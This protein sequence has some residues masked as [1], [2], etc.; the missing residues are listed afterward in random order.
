[1][2]W[3]NACIFLGV[4]GRGTPRGNDCPFVLLAGKGAEAAAEAAGAPFCGVC[5]HF[6][7]QGVKCSVCGHLGHREASGMEASAGRRR[8][9][10]AAD[11]EARRVRNAEYV[12][13]QTARDKSWRTRLAEE[14][15]ERM[16]ARCKRASET[17]ESPE[18]RAERRPFTLA[19]PAP[20]TMSQ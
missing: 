17:G 13:R 14:R 5:Q 4:R 12:E 7:F 16:Q 9:A 6:H 20:E 19:A 18:E 10:E 8:L 3:T 1:M 2:L 11:A 15:E